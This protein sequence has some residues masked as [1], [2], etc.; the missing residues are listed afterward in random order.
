MLLEVKNLS[1]HFQIAGRSVPIV[2]DLSFSVDEGRCLALVGESGC[3]KSMTALSL[4]RL[5][6][7][8]GRIASGSVL[9]A[10]K[11]LL[12]HSV[13]QMYKVRGH[14]MS[15]IFQEPMTSL[16]P[17]MR[18]GAQVEEAV[19]LHEKVSPKAARERGLQLFK[20]VGIPD[21][22]ARFST[23]PHQMSGGLKQRVMIAMALVTR[24]K[25]L[26]ADEPTTALDVTIQAQ[27]IQLLRELQRDFQ[28]A[29][30]LITHDLGVVN[31]IADEIAVMY[32]GRIVEQAPRAQLLAAPQHPY[33]RGLLSALPGR[34]G[35][36]VR[37]T[38]IQG[39]VPSPKNW[40]QGCRFQD[41]CPLV[42]SACR[43]SI[44]PLIG[45]ER[46]NRVACHAVQ[47][48]PGASVLAPSGPEQEVES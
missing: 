6:P 31:Q 10:G 5:L 32:A 37:L 18:V 13:P 44:P 22:E 27:I 16:N 9:L 41:R 48:A 35:P 34:A 39:T 28:T 20:R 8:A 19:L 4:L 15:M 1:C 30:L 24:P 40:P 36:K 2:D 21:P 14:E 12:R 11:D 17:V 3:G 45:E 38:E 42:H 26:L 33:T 46:A 29:I 23:Y 43:T 47:A 7:K 25:V